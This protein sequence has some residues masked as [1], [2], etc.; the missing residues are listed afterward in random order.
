MGFGGMITSKKINY[1][2]SP[3]VCI[4]VQGLRGKD[5]HI[6]VYICIYILAGYMYLK[7]NI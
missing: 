3:L 2:Y 7:F 6:H 5:S 1:V 4:Y